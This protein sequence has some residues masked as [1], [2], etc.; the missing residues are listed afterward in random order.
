[1]IE[2]RQIDKYI[3]KVFFFERMRFE[4]AML[5][6]LGA[7]GV[8]LFA[9]WLSGSQSSEPSLPTRESTVSWTSRVDS[10]HAMV[11]SACLIVGLKMALCFFGPQCIV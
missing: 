3:I 7:K 2:S 6:V 4:G 11:L 10:I 9:R 1:L 5:S 8:F